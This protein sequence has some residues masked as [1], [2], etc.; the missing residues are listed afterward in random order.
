M[1][2]LKRLMAQ[3]D[4]SVLINH[5]TTIALFNRVKSQTTSTRYLSV[6][7]DMTRFTGSDGKPVTGA[8]PPPIPSTNSL[9]PGFTANANVWES[10][11][12]WLVDPNK[13]VGPSFAPPLQPDWPSAPANAIPQQTLAPVIRYNSTVVLQSLQTGICSPVLVI[14]RVE[15]DAEVVGMDGQH[16]ESINLPCYPEG[17]L[18]GDPVSQLQK[19]AF[20]AYR[21][22][23]MSYAAQDPRYGGMWLSCDQEAVQ[24]KMVQSERKWSPIP[25]PTR[26]SSSVPS[27]PQQRFGVLPMTPHNSSIN[28]PSTPSSPISSSSSTVDYFGPHSRKASSSSLF[29]PNG[30]DVPLPNMASNDVGPVRRQRTGSTGR[31]PMGRPMAHHKRKSTD[32]SA[33]SSYDHLPSLAQAATSLD[34]PSRVQW[35]LDVGD[36]CIWS[37]VSTEQVTYT[38]YVPPYV[39]SYKEPVAPFPSLSRALPPNASADSGPPRLNHQWTNMTGLPLVTL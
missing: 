13:P 9:F 16:T 10:F 1:S 19:V 5:G 7:T 20:E 24:S 21:V 11:I 37:I 35:T 31:G 36:V 8:R 17:E 25:Q 2:S 34:S 15:Q 22:E 14:R 12:I 38:F 28:L 30:G 3:A 29:S 6:Q 33:S 18:P 39:E 27:T 23:S 4:N 26:K 32:H